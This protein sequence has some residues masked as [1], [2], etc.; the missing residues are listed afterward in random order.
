MPQDAEK[1]PPSRWWPVYTV[2]LLYVAA[3]ILL[4][5]WLTRHFRP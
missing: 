3:V 1:M 2:T 5:D 4:L